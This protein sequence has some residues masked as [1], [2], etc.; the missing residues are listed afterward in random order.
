[1]LTLFR[2]PAAKVRPA[3]LETDRTTVTLYTR[4][5]CC[6]CHKA[7]EVIE[8]FRSRY[9]FNLECVDIDGDPELVEAHGQTVPV[10]AVDGKIRFRGVVNPV[11][12]GRLFV[13]REDESETSR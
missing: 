8:S 4:A 1:M 5:R 9:N 6:C 3:S 2:R 13:A 12:F 10:V 7:L 11:L